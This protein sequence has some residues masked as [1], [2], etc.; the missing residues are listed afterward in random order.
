MEICDQELL[1][2]E[3]EKREPSRR[4]VM[5]ALRTADAGLSGLGRSAEK[6]PESA[7]FISKLRN[8]ITQLHNQLDDVTK[9]PDAGIQGALEPELE[10]IRGLLKPKPAPVP[11]APAA[12]TATETAAKPAN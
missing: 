3:E 5:Y 4:I 7:S 10:A 1:R 12:P 6:V 9:V 11:A 8:K 2:A